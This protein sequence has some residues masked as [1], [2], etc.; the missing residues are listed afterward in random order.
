MLDEDNNYFIYHNELIELTD[1]ETDLLSTLLRNKDK[2]IRY[3]ELNNNSRRVVRKL[4][5]KLQWRLKIKTVRGVG[6]IV[7]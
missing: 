6:F 1:I 7:E 5:E 2:V 3:E 4:R